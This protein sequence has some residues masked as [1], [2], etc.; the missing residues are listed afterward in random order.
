MDKIIKGSK[1]GLTFT[2]KHQKM[3][4]GTKYN[5]VAIPKS[6][7]IYIIPS[8]SSKGLKISKKKGCNKVYSLIDI[9]NKQV[10]K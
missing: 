6:N 5:Y 10:K 4:I 9:R 7:K 8:N 2:F 3:K 1:R